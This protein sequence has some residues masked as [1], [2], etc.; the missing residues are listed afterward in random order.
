M[1]IVSKVVHVAALV[2][3]LRIASLPHAR[4]AH[5]HQLAAVLY[6][7][8]A[9]QEVT[10]GYHAAALAFEV[11]HLEKNSLYLT[12]QAPM[13][14]WICTKDWYCKCPQAR[15]NTLQQ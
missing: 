12:C 3:V 6:H 4:L 10:C 14:P 15:S 5:A 13:D 8:L 7:K 2:A 9:T 11:C 1:V